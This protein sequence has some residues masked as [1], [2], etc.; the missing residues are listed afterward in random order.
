MFMCPSVM[1]GGYGGSICGIMNKTVTVDLCFV[2][3]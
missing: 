1:S 3:R 2:P